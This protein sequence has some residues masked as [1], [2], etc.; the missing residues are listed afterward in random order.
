MLKRR[1]L[2]SRARLFNNLTL[3]SES[4]VIQVLIEILSAPQI[5]IP[6]IA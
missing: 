3:I 5:V 6:K 1:V 4:R 2:D